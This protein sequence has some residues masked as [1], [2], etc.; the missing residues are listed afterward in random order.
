MQMKK[1]SDNNP[2]LAKL[3]FNDE[4]TQVLSEYMGVCEA[5]FIRRQVRKVR[6]RANQVTSLALAPKNLAAT[7]ITML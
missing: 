7:Y 6:L 3:E 2:D 5:A 4:W 1:I